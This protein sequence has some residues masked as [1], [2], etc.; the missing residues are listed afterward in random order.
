MPAPQRHYTLDDYFE[1]EEISEIKHEF[2]RGEIF[3]MA[4]ASLAHNDI[5]SNIHAALRTGLRGTGCR[6]FG[7]DLR[8]AAP[9]GPYTYADVSVV[10]GPVELVPERPDTA[11]NPTVI[12][13]VL[14]DA[15]RDYDRGD[16]FELYKQIS[17]LREY[18]LV[19]QDRVHVEH[20]WRGRGGVWR[21]RKLVRPDATLRFK[22]GGIELPIEDVYREVFAAP[23]GP[24]R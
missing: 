24:A 6:A 2:H 4:G 23:H 9:G 12:V 13:E 22:T 10:C 11:T 8:L 18:V 17:T 20:W 1:V 14:S 16:K 15:T 21:M 3:A 5:A 7:S 19:E